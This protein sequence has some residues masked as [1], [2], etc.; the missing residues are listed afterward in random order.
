MQRKC[1][2]SSNSNYVVLYLDVKVIF[3]FDGNLL[4]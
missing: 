2:R 4:R 1:A 3:V